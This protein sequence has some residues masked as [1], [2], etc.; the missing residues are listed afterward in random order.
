MNIIT[1]TSDLRSFNLSLGVNTG[2]ILSSLS[3]VPSDEDEKMMLTHTSA[4][5]TDSF[6]IN[7]VDK[8]DHSTKVDMSVLC[9]GDEPFEFFTVGSVK[10]MQ[11]LWLLMNEDRN[12]LPLYIEASLPITSGGSINMRELE[13]GRESKPTD[14]AKVYIDKNQ[15]YFKGTDLVDVPIMT[16][17]GFNTPR[18]GS[19]LFK[20]E[21]HRKNLSSTE[22]TYNNISYVGRV[23]SVKIDSSASFTKMEEKYI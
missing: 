5:Q 19:F 17:N 7:D 12:N 18:V 23:M 16:I 11:N 2:D 20:T 21:S 10:D 6:F 9:Y 14:S 22:L 4:F 8:F 3:A 1:V 15:K 13:L